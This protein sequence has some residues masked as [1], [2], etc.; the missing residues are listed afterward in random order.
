MKSMRKGMP[1]A[2]KMDLCLYSVYHSFLRLT[3]PAA[4]FFVKNFA[5]GG[6]EAR[7]PLFCRPLCPAPTRSAFFSVTLSGAAK[8][9][10]SREVEW[11]LRASAQ[12]TTTILH[13]TL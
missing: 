10:P 11:V 13:S 9:Q 12:V 7:M 5:V 3:I 4:K 6:V 8:A 1:F 2:E